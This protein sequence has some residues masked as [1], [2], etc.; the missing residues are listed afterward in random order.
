M[1]FACGDNSRMGFG[2][3]PSWAQNK[4]E[5]TILYCGYIGIMDNEWKLL[6]YSGVYRP[7]LLKA[8]LELMFNVI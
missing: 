1:R 4:M 2:L 7:S 6:S 8:R 5:T 3:H